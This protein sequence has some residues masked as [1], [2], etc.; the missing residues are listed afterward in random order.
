MAIGAKSRTGLYPV[1]VDD[2]QG[3]E[4]HVF[5]IEIVGKRKRMEGLEPAVVGKPSFA[6]APDVVHVN[7]L[8]DTQY[9]RMHELKGAVGRSLH[10]VAKRPDCA[11]NA[12]G[13][14]SVNVGR[15]GR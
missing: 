10:V 13:L 7:L 15:K 1:L 4:L 9:G 2:P 5:R 3:T 8:Q 6:A 14:S 12:S 11:A